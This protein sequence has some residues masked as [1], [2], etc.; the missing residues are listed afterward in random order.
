MYDFESFFFDIAKKKKNLY[1]VS[2]KDKLKHIK[3]FKCL[4]VDHFEPGMH[5]AEVLKKS[6]HRNQKRGFYREEM[7]AKQ[8]NDLIGYSLSSYLIWEIL[9]GCL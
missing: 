4:S 6:H 8:A 3:F 5:K 1:V 2:L 9:V 7:Q